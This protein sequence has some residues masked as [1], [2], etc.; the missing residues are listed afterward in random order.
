MTAAVAAAPGDTIAATF[1]GG[2]GTVTA[3]FAN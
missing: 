1:A 2:L 3:N